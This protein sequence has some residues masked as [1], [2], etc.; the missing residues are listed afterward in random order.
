MQADA[1]MNFKSIHAK[2]NKYV[3]RKVSEKWVVKTFGNLI[4]EELRETLI[5]HKMFESIDFTYDR[6]EGNLT[7]KIGKREFFYSSILFDDWV[8]GSYNPGHWKVLK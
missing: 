3:M 1:Q 8:F 4:I 7:V 5:L 6:N 2:M